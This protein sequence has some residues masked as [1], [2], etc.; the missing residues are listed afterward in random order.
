MFFEP[1]NIWANGFESEFR[2]FMQNLKYFFDKWLSWK[3]GYGTFE[4][5]QAIP[6]TFT[7]DRDLMIDETE[8]INNINSLGEELSQE[9]RDELN[10]YIENHEKEEERRE[11]DRKKAEKR[12][13]LIQFGN[14]VNRNDEENEEDKENK[15]KIPS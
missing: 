15:Q 12:D 9:T 14:T 4:E 11:A 10:P 6:I 5:L 13:E 1:L 3:G 2:V 8:I 7:L